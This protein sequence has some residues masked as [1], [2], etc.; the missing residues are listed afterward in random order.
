LA[1][2]GRASK[3]DE[4]SSDCRSD[5]NLEGGP[6]S[7]RRACHMCGAVQHDIRRMASTINCVRIVVEHDEAGKRTGISGA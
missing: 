3:T 7:S 1:H 4:V 6:K 2:S 5:G